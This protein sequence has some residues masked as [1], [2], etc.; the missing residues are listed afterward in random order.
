MG[1][2]TRFS[3]QTAALLSALLEA[4]SDWHYG[5]D[6]SR[7][8]ALKSGTLYP[9]LMRLNERNWLETKWEFAPDNG[10]PRHLYR[11]TGEGRKRARNLLKDRTA[12]K[13]ALRPQAVR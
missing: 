8:T 10:R 2:D 7:K 1:D 4:P 5:Y 13:F 12:P 11:L 9:I 3:R 6:L